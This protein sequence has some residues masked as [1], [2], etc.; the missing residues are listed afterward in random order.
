MTDIPA[1]PGAAGGTVPVVELDDLTGWLTTTDHKRIG[2]LYMVSA[3]AMFLVGG[4][5]AMTMRIELAAPGIQLVDEAGYDQ[6]FTM[7]GTIMLLLFG[8][9]M[10]V[11]LANYIVPLQI[12]ASEMAFPRI[13][14]LSFWLF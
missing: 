7:H 5:L 9:P 11:G 8:T 4:V 14:A 10:A 6:L 13:N 12:G 1:R 3:F 2:V